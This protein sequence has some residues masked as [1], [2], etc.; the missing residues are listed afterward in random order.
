MTAENPRSIP[1]AK[2]VQRLHVVI[3]GLLNKE[4]WK[5]AFSYGG[6]LHVH[7]GAHIASAHPKLPAENE[8]EW[9]L[10]T[11]GTA[12]V[13]HTR[14]GTIGSTGRTD[15]NEV[16]LEKKLGKHLETSNVSRLEGGKS[17]IVTFNNGCRFCVTPTAEDDRSDLPYWELFMPHNMMVIFGPRNQWSYKRSDLPV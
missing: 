2:D 3:G 15:T 16:Q 7:F 12:W 17:L 11:F 14:D 9:I 1:H 13:L 6:E 10:N 5:V 4:C 8:G